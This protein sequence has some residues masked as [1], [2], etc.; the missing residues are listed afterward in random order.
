FLRDG[1]TRGEAISPFSS[2]L[3]TRQ[4]IFRHDEKIHR[5]KMSSVEDLCA[6]FRQQDLSGA[7]QLINPFNPSEMI[8]RGSQLYNDVKAVCDDKLTSQTIVTVPVDR[9][10]PVYQNYP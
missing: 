6:L 3:P 10:Y 5:E 9:Y 7:V 8:L 4:I 2:M 1:K